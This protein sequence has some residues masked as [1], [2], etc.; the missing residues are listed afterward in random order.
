MTDGD[1]GKWTVIIIVWI[2]LSKPQSR[3]IPQVN[4]MRRLVAL[5]IKNVRPGES[6]SGTKERVK[7]REGR[8][9]SG[10]ISSLPERQKRGNRWVDNRKDP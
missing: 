6:F 1:S 10:V 3:N 4:D 7:R 2:R 9:S 5:R 8:P